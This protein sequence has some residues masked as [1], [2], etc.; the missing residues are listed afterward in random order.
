[1]RNLYEILE[2]GEQATQQEIKSAYRKLAKKY[3]PDLNQ[4][5]EEAQEKFKEVNTAYEVLSNE[6]KRAQYDR[7][8]DS[9]FQNGGAGAGGAGYGDFGDIF[10]D[11]FGDLFGG[12]G[13]SRGAR[14]QDPNAPRMGADVRVDVTIPFKEAVFGGDQE[15]SYTRIINCKECNGTGAEKGSAK[16]TCDTCHGSGRVQF[17]QNSMFGQFIR[18]EVCPDCHGTGEKIE[19]TCGHCHGEGMERKKRKL[20]VKVP[21]GVD[22]GDALPIRGEGHEG[23]NN[24]PAGDLYVVFR[25]QDHPIFER[26]GLDIHFEMPI[27]FAQAAMGGVLEIPTLTGKEDYEIKEGTETGTRFHLKDKGIENM[28]GQKGDLYFTVKIQTPKKLTEEQKVLLKRYAEA[29]GEEVH[30]RRKGIF[31]KVKDFFD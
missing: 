20:R 29:S 3:H 4:G 25:V 11:I 26:H 18:E 23:K 21:K 31:D 8:G 17:Q 14:R 12:G 6:Q 16:T 15:V 13:F 10:G 2:V 1:M 22:T 7:F 24:G 30:E 19:K 28:R 27:T 5:N 9:I